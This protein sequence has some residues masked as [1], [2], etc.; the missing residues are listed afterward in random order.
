MQ[1]AT[2]AP[3]PEPQTRIPRSAR[4]SWIASPISRLVGVVDPHRVGVGAEVE[5]LVPGDRFEH[6]VTQVNAAVVEGDRDLHRTSTRAILPSSN[7]KR[8]GSVRPSASTIAIA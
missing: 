8:I 1:A 7:V 3:T 2:D 5:H 4:P 6:G